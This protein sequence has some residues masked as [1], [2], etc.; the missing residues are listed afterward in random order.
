MSLPAPMVMRLPA[1]TDSLGPEGHRTR[2][3]RLSAL[4]RVSATVRLRT[5]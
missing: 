2:I 3:F 4:G 1:I 5:C